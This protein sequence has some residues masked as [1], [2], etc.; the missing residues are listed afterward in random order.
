MPESVESGKAAVGGRR[1]PRAGKLGP[2]GHPAGCGGAWWF[3]RRGFSPELCDGIEIKR[4]G[5][6][7]LLRVAAMRVAC[8]RG[9][10]PELCDEIEI[11]R[12]GLKA[13][14]RGRWVRGL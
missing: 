9:F 5:L 6:K 10:S 12:S 7:A 13:L 1:F 4:S 3:R 2:E 14:L 11:K 8:R